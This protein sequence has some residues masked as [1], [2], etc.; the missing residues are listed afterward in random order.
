[1]PVLQETVPVHN[2]HRSV[3]RAR[4]DA[5]AEGRGKT[6]VYLRADQTLGAAHWLAQWAR[7]KTIGPVSIMSTPVEPA[8]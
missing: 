4:S 1:M 7:W 3:R 6:T 2:C 5:G 8:T